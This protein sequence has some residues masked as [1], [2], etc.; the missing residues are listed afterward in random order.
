MSVFDRG[1]SDFLAIGNLLL[2]IQNQYRNKPVIERDV[3]GDIKNPRIFAGSR[4]L[5]TRGVN[6][7]PLVKC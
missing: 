2:Q 5:I 3:V 7:L 4:V 6:R 1:L